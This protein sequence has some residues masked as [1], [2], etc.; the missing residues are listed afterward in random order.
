[1]RTIFFLSLI[2]LTV[3]AINGQNKG[4]TDPKSQRIEKIINSQWTFNY[5]PSE[6]ADKGYEALAFNDSRWMVVSIPHTWSTYETTGELHPFIRNASEGD[7]PY[8]WTGWGWYR[9]HFSVSKEI[10]NKKIFL[11]FEGV[12]KY[13]KVWINGKLLG[14]HKG[15][16]TSFDF[17]ITQYV[18]PG[19]DNVLAIA[20]N[21]QQNDKFKIPPMSGGSF[22]T[23]GGIYRDVSIVIKDKLYIPMQGSTIHEG[24]TFIT[25]PSVSAK[26]AI[27]RVQTWVKN[28]N[29]QK[30]SCILQT[31]LI[32]ATG[33]VVQLLKS[34]VIIDPG[35]I[36]RFDQTSKPVKAP[37]LWSRESPYIYKVYSE[38]IDNKIVVDTYTSPLGFRWF[39]WDN[40][41][42]VL[43]LN[44]KKVV[45]HGININ[46]DFPWLG[47]ARPKSLAL[48]DLADINENLNVNFLR[49]SHFPGEK[50][51]YDYADKSGIIV[52]EES[53]NTQNQA[54]GKE[55]QEQQMKEMIRRDRN[56]P[57]ILFWS[58]GSETGNPADVRIT[59][60]EDT[61][62]IV[63]GENLTNKQG[64]PETKYS[65]EKIADLKT[66]E[67]AVRGWNII[68]ANQSAASANIQLVTENDQLDKLIK[69]SLSSTRNF[70]VW[71]YE[72]HGADVEF[73]NSPVFHVDTRGLSDIYRNP[74]YSYFLLQANSSVK[75]VIYI[76]PQFWNPQFTGQKKDIIVCSNCE[77][78]ELKVNGISKGSLVPDAL[79]FHTVVFKDIQVEPGTLSAIGTLNG[80]QI[81]SQIN[82]SEAP[83][84]IVLTASHT[85]IIADAGSVIV[86]KADITDSKGNHVY[87][88]NNPV[89]WV[90]SG[91]ASFVGPSVFESEI[92]KHHEQEGIGY[93]DMPVSNIIRS[94]GKPGKIKVTVYGSGILSG[95]VEITAEAAGIDK[96]VIVEPMLSG[97]GRKP[98]ERIELKSNVLDDIPMEINKVNADLSITVTDKNGYRK[99]VVD[100]L[101]KNSTAIDTTTAEFRALTDILVTQLYNNVGKIGIDDINF[102]IEHFNKCRL[103]SGYIVATKLPQQFKDV[104]KK[105]YAALIIKEG[106]ERNAG[107]EMNWLNWIPSGG[108]VV[109]CQDN[110]P[111]TKDKTIIYTRKN[112]L[113]DIIAAV[114]PQFVSYSDE[115][116]ERALTFI[117]KMNPYIRT[118]A[119]SQPGTDGNGEFITTYTYKAIQGQPILIPLQKFITN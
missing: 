115:A 9:K 25:T 5:F 62:R 116:K 94:T 104:L 78:V 55:V 85:K 15:G 3:S 105:Y 72:D 19:E 2:C 111:A 107:D 8:W 1:M 50:G 53:P 71:A 96:S 65:L 36:Y 76:N 101:I 113:A 16:Y 21:N 13:C 92:N 84:K 69:S 35:Q 81:T 100:F 38:V 75:P 70:L 77:K 46:Q 86:I 56:H 6:T 40:K 45:F 66:L 103:I 93:L 28:E 42:N 18:K 106:R 10:T 12:Q 43:Y 91:P 49:T 7:N 41:E 59:T 52:C 51:I 29:Q 88:A 67:P 48:S 99:P 89:K 82:M 4:G 114:Y 63:T 64:A 58:V 73:L 14:D 95:S 34:E 83:S 54:F 44:D 24:G 110:I 60:A 17:D 33:K 74:K 39:R 119:S 27:V 61:T 87:G 57:S 37:R 68:N 22:T 20:V 98:V 79:N 97:D 23:Y 32:D 80:K 11:E 47:D 26:E 108:T 102:N 31:S 112:D 118:T 90:V 30:K 117:S 109:I